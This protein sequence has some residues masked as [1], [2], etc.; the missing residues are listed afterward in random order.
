MPDGEIA[1]G[2]HGE[3]QLFAIG[4]NARETSALAF[5]LRMEKRIDLR[6][7]GTSL[8]IEGETKQVVTHLTILL[9]HRHTVC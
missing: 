8:R 7:K 1:V 6:A 2:R 9:R 3:H 5:C 4:R